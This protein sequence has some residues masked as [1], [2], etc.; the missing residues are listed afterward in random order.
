MKLLNPISL[1]FFCSSILSCSRNIALEKDWSDPQVK[2]QLKNELKKDVTFIAYLE[3]M[4]TFQIQSYLKINVD[5]T[6]YDSTA[7]IKARNN[8]RTLDESL[9][10][11]G[12][13]ADKSFTDAIERMKESLLKL[14]K[15]YPGTRYFNVQDW[16]DLNQK[17]LDQ[18][19]KNNIAP[20]LKDA[21]SSD[22]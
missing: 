12:G 5:L 11:A 21:Y 4:K 17:E 7:F 14:Y 13:K 9:S 19:F 10:I 8:G 20:R 18:N 1:L 15:K 22:N 6:K 2:R 16:N 3:A